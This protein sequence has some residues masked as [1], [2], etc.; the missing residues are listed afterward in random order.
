MLRIHLKYFRINVGDALEVIRMGS[1]S[2]LR[3]G[4]STLASIVLNKTGESARPLSGGLFRIYLASDTAFARPLQSVAAINGVVRFT[5]L[6]PG[7]YVVR[8]IRAPLGY[9][10]W[11]N[12]VPVSLAVDPA[13]N[14]ISDMEITQPFTDTLSW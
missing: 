1:P 10:I 11:E 12:D 9:R 6:L 8:E 2:L 5:N 7:D 14:T 4:L 13:T 3:T